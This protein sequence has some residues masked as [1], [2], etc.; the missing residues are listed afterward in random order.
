MAKSFNPLR[1]WKRSP[2]EHLYGR[3][4]GAQQDD[5][6][7][8]H[9]NQ[10]MCFWGG[11]GG[12]GEKDREHKLRMLSAQ[13]LA[14]RKHPSASTGIRH[15]HPRVRVW[16]RQVLADTSLILYKHVTNSIYIG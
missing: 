14:G 11:G 3:D 7:H 5:Q 13:V 9:L 15:P 12:G 8:A 1:S 2:P 10:P 6:L 16:R 4:D